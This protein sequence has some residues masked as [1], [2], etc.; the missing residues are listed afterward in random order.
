MPLLS[1]LNRGNESIIGETG[2]TRYK[3]HLLDINGIGAK[4]NIRGRLKKYERQIKRFLK[5]CRLK[6][7]KC[8][9]EKMIKLKELV[10]E[11]DSDIISLKRNANRSPPPTTTGHYIFKI[12]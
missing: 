3:V 5:F 1:D 6:C 2:C 12:C 11:F 10:D 9:W 7:K 4:E 8:H